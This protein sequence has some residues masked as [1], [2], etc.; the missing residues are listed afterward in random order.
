MTIVIHIET[1]EE[2]EGYK[3]IATAI[4]SS[5]ECHGA[6]PSADELTG[7]EEAALISKLGTYIPAIQKKLGEF[8]ILPGFAPIRERPEPKQDTYTASAPDPAAEEREQALKAKIKDLQR[9]LDLASEFQV[10]TAM[11][12]QILPGFRVIRVVAVGGPVSWSIVNT[13]GWRWS[14]VANAMAPARTIKEEHLFTSLDEA[15]SVARAAYAAA[16]KQKENL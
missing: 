11:E 8:V 5:L 7:D 6:E 1:N 3:T 4:K 10:A 15:T 14:K 13:A 2:N 12:E 16:L 9:Q